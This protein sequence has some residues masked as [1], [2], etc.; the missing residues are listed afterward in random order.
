M[1][2]L[3]HTSTDRLY[4]LRDRAVRNRRDPYQRQ[5]IAKIDR[6]LARRGL[7]VA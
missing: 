2:D 3:L 1:N 4:D 5:R 7:L 6:E